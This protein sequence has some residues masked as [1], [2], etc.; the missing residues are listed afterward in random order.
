ML[1]I[2]NGDL[3]LRSRMGLREIKQ[4]ARGLSLEQLK[5][6]EAWLHQE[7]THRAE[8]AERKEESPPRTQILEERSSNNRTYRLQG[9]RCGKERCKCADG[10]LHGP[11][12]YAYWSENGRTRSQYVGKRL[13]GGRGRKRS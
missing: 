5:K 8:E 11:Y 2:E 10:E 1:L 9:I 3:A 4:A 12:W 6:L 13:P 7:L